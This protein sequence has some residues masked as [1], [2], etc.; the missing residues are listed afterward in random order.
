M[1]VANVAVLVID[2]NHSIETEQ[3]I[4]AVLKSR[5]VNITVML[6]INGSGEEHEHRLI[7]AFSGNPKVVIS[8]TDKNVGFT[9]A[10]NILIMKMK[11]AGIRDQYILLLNNDACVAP[12][13]VAKLLSVLASQ[14]DIGAVGPR[15]MQ[16]GKDSIIAADGACVW[17]RLMQQSFM[18][19]GKRSQ[20]C[21][22]LPP[23]EVPFISGACMLIHTDIFIKLGGFDARFFAYFE[24]WDLCLR[25]RTSG[26]RC[27]HVA[28]AVVWHMGSLTTG[29]DSLIYHF[30]MTR[31]RYLMARKHLPL[32]IFVFLFLPYFMVSRV[33]YKVIFLLLRKRL[34]GIKGI[35]LALAWIMAPASRKSAF[36]PITNTLHPVSGN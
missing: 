12:D 28:D 30:L 18:N 19:S 2:L 5:S 17:R 15:I 6:H 24:D 9:G 35:M 20:D 33:A 10:I 26:Y 21:P 16:T 34:Q 8:R 4:T 23:F 36:W 13:T 14:T 31:N 22:V 11:E 1:T 7:K 32:H 25:M 27:L 29:T 3:A